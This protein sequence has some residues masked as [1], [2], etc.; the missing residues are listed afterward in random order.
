MS[1]RRDSGTQPMNREEAFLM[2]EKWFSDE[3]AVECFGTLF[4]WGLKLNGKVLSVSRDEV[5]VGLKDKA[6]IVLRLDVPGLQFIY[7]E[8]R[9][10]SPD[11]PGEMKEIVG[12]LVGFPRRTSAGVLHER[13]VFALR[14]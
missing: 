6:V 14:G 12:F 11:S 1:G 13:L 9:E 4:G 10:E 2:F 5:T 8:I 3:G 7:G